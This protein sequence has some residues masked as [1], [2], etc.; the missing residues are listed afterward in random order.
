MAFAALGAAAVDVVT[1]AAIC[2]LLCGT[3]P[4]VV[5]PGYVLLTGVAAASSLPLGAG[6]LD[7]GLFAL[8]TSRLGV[9]TP[10]ALAAVACYRICG[11]GLTLLTGG[12][13]LVLDGDAGITALSNGA[14]SVKSRERMREAA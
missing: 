10:D 7:A 6:V 2:W 3:D 11:P 12:L 1:C 4:F 14:G 9:Q 5:A 8:L 13:V